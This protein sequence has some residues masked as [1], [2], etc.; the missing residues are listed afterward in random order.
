MA[1]TWNKEELELLYETLTLEEI[2]QKYGVSRER[3]RQVMDK[4]KIKR[5]APN[6]Q[7]GIGKNR[8][9]EVTDQ[10]AIPVCPDCRGRGFIEYNHGLIQMPCGKCQ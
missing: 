9:A 8:K 7:A 5:R 6:P 4:F 10:V 1:N 3:V 2:G